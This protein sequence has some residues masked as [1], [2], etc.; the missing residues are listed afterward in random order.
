MGDFQ[1]LGG[2]REATVETDRLR[3]KLLICMSRGT[4]SDPKFSTANTATDFSTSLVASI[5]PLSERGG[6]PLLTFI[7]ESVVRSKTTYSTL[8]VALYYIILLKNHVPPHDFTQEQWRRRTEIQCGRQM[9]LSALILAA[10]YL[11]DKNYSTS[12]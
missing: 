12:V 1:L 3:D 11:Q 9:F 8:Q 2:S 5:W 4:T 6:M 10:K 7:S